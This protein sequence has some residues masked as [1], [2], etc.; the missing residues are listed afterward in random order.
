MYRKK[1]SGPGVLVYWIEHFS[2]L[3]FRRWIDVKYLSHLYGVYDILSIDCRYGNHT[4]I[5][6]YWYFYKNTI[7]YNPQKHIKGCI[8]MQCRTFSICFWLRMFSSS[9]GSES[10]LST[11]SF[12]MFVL[13]RSVFI[14]SGPLLF[15]KIFRTNGRDYHFKS[16]INGLEVKF[17]NDLSLS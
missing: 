16:K 8:S 5:L 2:F 7:D 15:L 17:S 10:T 6:K 1:I 14:E 13:L 9:S 4:L 11:F 3:L 12:Y